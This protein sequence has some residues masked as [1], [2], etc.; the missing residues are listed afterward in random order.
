MANEL[1]ITARG[2]KRIETKLEKL[3]RQLPEKAD[4]VVNASIINAHGRMVSDVPVD[5]GSLKSSI[6][7]SR[8][9]DGWTIEAG[10]S[11][12]PYAPYVEFG[13]GTGVMAYDTFFLIDGL[14]KYALQFK[15]SPRKR[16]R[17]AMPKQFFFYNWFEER[18]RLIDQLQDMIRQEVKK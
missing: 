13:T 16:R 5:S 15:A 2:L 12:A 3:T 4:G 1:T 8:I 11:S 14:R 9:K 7:F 10:G 6:K 17:N 18:Q